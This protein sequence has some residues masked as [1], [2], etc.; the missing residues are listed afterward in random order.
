M[1]KKIFNCFIY[2]YPL[3][4]IS[5]YQKLHIEVSSV[6]TQNAQEAPT[7]ETL[8][9]LVLDYELQQARLSARLIGT[10][11]PEY[12][13]VGFQVSP[14]MD[15][16]NR[17]DIA[18]SDVE[19][20]E[21]FVV[22][23]TWPY[24]PPFYVRAYAKSSLTIGYGDILIFNMEYVNSAIL[25]LAVQ[26]QDICNVDWETAD[27]ICLNSIVGNYSDWRLPDRNEL[28]AIYQ[29]KDDFNRFSLDCTYWTSELADVQHYYC[30]NFKDGSVSAGSNKN[31]ARCVRSLIY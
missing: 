23:D 6:V 15:F 4:V 26:S 19:K 20:G 30:V 25:G 2:L 27:N 24:T 11:V 8:D 18:A 14:D 13:E 31:N 3:L 17:K 16:L 9:V 28:Q 21:C 5:C 10:G 1:K 29:M 22:L 12:E 7:V